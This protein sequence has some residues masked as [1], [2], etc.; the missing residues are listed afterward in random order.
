M[1]TFTDYIF[2]EYFTLY[3]KVSDPNKDADGMGT[4]E[5]FNRCIGAEIDEYL[6]PLVDNMQQNLLEPLNCLDKFVPFLESLLGFDLDWVWFFIENLTFQ[7]NLL[8]II[9]RMYQI[10]GTIPAHVI[11]C[12]WLG[13]T[14]T[15][16]EVF[17]DDGVYD[18]GGTWDDDGGWDSF[19]PSC[20]DYSLDLA[21]HGPITDDDIT[22]IG[23]IVEFNRP[24]NAN[25]TG[26]MYTDLDA[27]PLSM[28]IVLKPVTNFSVINPSIP[29]H[30]SGYYD[31]K[32]EQDMGS[33]VATNG[34]ATSYPNS[35]SASYEENAG[36]NI[37]SPYSS[38]PEITG[39]LQAPIFLFWHI[40]WA[41]GLSKM[42]TWWW[43]S[44]VSPD[45]SFEDTVGNKAFFA[46]FLV[47]DTLTNKLLSDVQPYGGLIPD[48]D[49]T[50]VSSTGSYATIRLTR[51]HA[52]IISPMSPSYSTFSM[53]WI[54]TGG[55]TMSIDPL[56][57][58]NDDKRIVVLPI[59]SYQFGVSAA[60]INTII[61][62][63]YPKS[64]MTLVLEVS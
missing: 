15:V 39:N 57:P 35:N 32:M 9:I 54:N 20:T 8:A 60:Y 62:V 55:Y 19:C 51:S 24:I 30:T 34:L 6:L 27:P 58:F 41:A 47:F 63:T 64:A 31:F 17:E 50:L 14:C 40:P 43:N 2:N 59:G 33:F 1:F 56:D 36:W 3:D 29:P 7:R 23:T 5:R 12:G 61:H 53:S 52:A 11:M 18:D 42:F 26:Y 48:L 38:A 46:P 4:H 44:L 16:V 28:A 13:F 45:V 37:G 21:G 25:Y 22:A 10:R 49:A